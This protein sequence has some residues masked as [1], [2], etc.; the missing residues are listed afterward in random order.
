[1]YNTEYTTYSTQRI[2]YATLVFMQLSPFDAMRFTSF[3]FVVNDIKKFFI[4]L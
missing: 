3:Q 2:F 4:L 1:M